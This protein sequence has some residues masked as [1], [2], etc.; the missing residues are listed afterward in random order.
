MSKQISIKPFVYR[1]NPATLGQ[2]FEE[3]LEMF[4]MAA[5]VDTVKAENT[6][7]YLLLNICEGGAHGG[8]QGQTKGHSRKLRRY[9]QEDAHRTLKPQVVLF[10]KA[11][12]LVGL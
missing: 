12:H 11:W 10:T 9:P 6:K 8:S 5:K 2:R 4:E 1:D 3:W 7:E